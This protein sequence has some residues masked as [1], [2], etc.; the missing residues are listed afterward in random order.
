MRLE[1]TPARTTL[2][3]VTILMACACGTGVNCA[4]LLTMGGMNTTP[5]VTH[6]VLLSIGAVLIFGGLWQ[7]HR[8]AAVLAAVSFV[9]VAAAAAITPPSMM[10]AAYQ[11]WH[12]PYI[13][14]ALLYLL[15]AGILGYA[16]WIAFPA[17]NGQS[18]AGKALALTGTAIATGCPCCLVTGALAGLAVTAG[19]S[20]WLFHG[21]TYFVGIGMAAIGLAI[22]RGFRPIPWLIAGGIIS[23]YATRITAITG[24]WMIGDVNLFFVLNY[25]LYLLGAA[26]IVKAWAVA[27]ERLPL[28]ERMEVIPAQPAF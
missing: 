7:I 1:L 9:A 19:G 4:K 2:I 16:V 15:F 21:S 22:F 6:S 3:G 17:P 10:T 8:R 12:E 13:G 26:L 25:F 23:H 14:G 11:P 18:P 27:Y 5:Q 28:S 24:A 20:A